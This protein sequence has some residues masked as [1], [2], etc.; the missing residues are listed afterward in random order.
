MQTLYIESTYTKFK[1]KIRVLSDSL[2]RRKCLVAINQRERS[3]KEKKVP[4]NNSARQSAV[5]IYGA[6]ATRLDLRED[7]LVSP[8]LSAVARKQIK[9]R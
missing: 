9:D 1:I 2:K 8:D 4:Q 5:S 3:K 6:A 7:T